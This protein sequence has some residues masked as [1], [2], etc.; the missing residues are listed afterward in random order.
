MGDETLWPTR[1]AWVYKGADPGTA[2][3]EIPVE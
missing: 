3:L 1:R 2:K